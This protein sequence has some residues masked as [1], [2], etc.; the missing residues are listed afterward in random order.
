MPLVVS[1]VPL[2]IF[3]LPVYDE[4]LPLIIST[5]R[6]SSYSKAEIIIELIFD[7]YES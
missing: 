7:E 4:M 3:R 1:A 5:I 6:A 2:G